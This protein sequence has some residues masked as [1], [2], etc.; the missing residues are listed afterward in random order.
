MAE[1]PDSWLI[2]WT[3][4]FEEWEGARINPGVLLSLADAENFGGTGFKP[5]N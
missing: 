3:Y 5:E 4:D 1:Q 2:D